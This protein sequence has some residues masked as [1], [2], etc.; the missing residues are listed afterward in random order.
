MLT[1]RRWSALALVLIAFAVLPGCGVTE[2][3]KNVNVLNGDA[4]EAGVQDA[5]TLVT[6]VPG[7]DVEGRTLIANIIRRFKAIM[8]GSAVIENAIGSPSQRPKYTMDTHERWIVVAVD[9]EERNKNMIDAALGALETAGKWV[10]GVVGVLGFIGTAIGWLR[11]SR[12]ASALDELVRLK[13]KT[14]GVLFRGIEDVDHKAT[15]ESIDEQARRAGIDDVVND[16]LLKVIP[17]VASTTGSKAAE[18]AP[19]PEPV[20]AGAPASD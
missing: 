17:H 12:K 2:A 9:E 6:H 15:K 13:D 11:A 19:A 18:P 8:A 5:T 16:E 10:G 20:P 3:T 14:L 1:G 4:A 7:V